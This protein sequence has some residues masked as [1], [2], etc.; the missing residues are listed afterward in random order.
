[1]AFVLRHRARDY[2]LSEGRF[3][4][5]RSESCHLCLEDPLASRNH[6][7]VLLLNEEVRVEDLE[8]RNGVFV[9]EER[10]NGSRLLAPGD[11][12]RI[13]GQEISLIRRVLQR[14]ETLAQSPVTQ[15]L[16]AFGV[17]GALAEKALAMGNGSEA[18]RI[19]GRQL[20]HLL[21]RAE[22]QDEL[23]GAVFEKACA[24]ALKIATLT[25]KPKWLDYL[26]RLHA[27]HEVLMN[28]ELVNELYS[29]SRK[30][31][32]ASRAHLRAYLESLRGKAVSFSPG[33]RFVLGRL[34]G[35]EALLN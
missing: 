18:E 3:L 22:H 5:G 33:E 29:L 9:N 14:T 27:S 11:Q 24:Y 13:G 4:I 16:Q 7:Q 35:L 30:I 17:L 26:F 23:E 32:G 6:A 19:L 12:I 34:E 1:M 10:I 28:A 25:R 15:R 8:S 31:S 20:E 21:E 2:P